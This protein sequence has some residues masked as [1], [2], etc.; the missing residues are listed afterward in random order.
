MNKIIK[1]MLNFKAGIILGFFVLTILIIPS[2]ALATNGYLR[3][4]N[5]VVDQG[6]NIATSSAGLPQ[7]NFTLHIAGSKD[8]S[9]TTYWTV[10]ITVSFSSN[11][12]SPNT[13][14]LGGQN[15]ADCQLF[16]LP[17]T[18]YYYSEESISNDTQSNWLTPK[19]YDGKSLSSVMTLSSVYSN[20]F[21]NTDPSDDILAN[22][23]SD[24]LV[25]IADG[26]WNTPSN[27]DGFRT[28]ILVNTYKSNSKPANTPPLISL[29]NGNP[30]T[31]IQGQV[32]NEPGAIATDL[33]D[34][35]ITNKIVYTGTVDTSSLGTS[36]LDYS[37]TDSGGLSASTTRNVIVVS[38]PNPS[39]T[40]LLPYTKGDIVV[41]TLGPSFG[42][43]PSL[44]AIASSS[45]IILSSQKQYQSFNTTATTTVY[46]K[47]INSYTDALDVFG[48]YVNGTST[49]T[50][51]FKVGNINSQNLPNIQSASNGQ[52]FAV[53]LPAG[54]IKFA[55]NSYFNSQTNFWS[56]EN[57]VN[58]GDD[59]M[60]AYDIL[61]TT[62]PSYLVA[63][64]DLPFN[65][66]D[67][68]YNDVV[69]SVS[70]ISCPLVNTPPL[71][72][73]IGNNPSTLTVGQTWNEPGAT[74]TDKEDGDLTNK[75]VITGTV[76]TTPGTYTL[77]YTVTDS[78]GLSA[79]TTRTVIVNPVIEN[80]NIN[81][82]ATNI[83]CD[84]ESDLPN[85]GVG[86]ADITASTTSQFLANH[87]NCRL[88]SDFKFQWGYDG[89][90]TNPG[91]N[92]IGEAATTTN[93]Y[94][95]GPTDANGV[96][97][98][99]INIA[100]TTGLFIREVLKDG[101]ILFSQSNNNVSAEMYC[102]TD[103]L[104]YDN[105]EFIGNPVKGQTYY[106]V[107]FNVLKPSLP[108]NTPPLISLIGNNPSTL[109]V[110]QTW[111]EPGATSTDKEDGDLTNKIV[112]TGTVGTTPGTY[113]LTYTVTDSGGLSAS[114]TRTVIVE[115]PV[116]TP[117]GKIK[118]CMSFADENNNIA[119]S[120]ANLPFGSFVVNLATSTNI[121]GSTIDSHTW[122]NTTFAPTHIILSST[123]DAECVIIDNLD[124][125]S[126]YYSEIGITGSLWDVRKYS[127]QY[128][129]PVNNIFD[130]FSYSP[131]LF[132]ATTTDDSSRNMNSDGNVELTN[133]RRERTIVLL[134][135][136]KKAPQCLVPDITSTLTAEATVGQ[137][138]SY[139]ITASSTA[140]TTLNFSIG[141]STLPTGLS[142]AT[143]TNTIFGVATQSGTF[144]I[145]LSATNSCGSDTKKLVLKVDP[146]Q[147]LLPELTSNTSAQAVVGQPFS[148]TLTASST[149]TISVAT[150]TLTLPAGLTYSTT[151]NTIS[152][153]PTETGTFSVNVSLKN[154][155]GV[156]S[157]TVSIVVNGLPGGG[158]G[159]GCT[160]NCGG[161]GGG[162]GGGN[163]PIVQN[164]LQ[165]FNEKV[166]EVTPGIAL[167]TWNTN[168]SA[169]KEVGYGLISIPQASSTAP[170]GYASSTLKI[171]SPLATV[172]SYAIPIDT[173]KTYYFRPVS[174]DTSSQVIGKELVLNPQQ[175][176]NQCYYL[177][178]YLKQGWDNNPV[179][180]K[181]LQVFLR[182]LEGFDVKVTGIYDD[183]TVNALNAFQNKY[184]DDIL[185]PWGHTAPTSF[186]YITTKKKVNEI[187]CK[188]AFPVTVSQQSEIDQYRNFLL[189]LQNAGVTLPLNTNIDG[190]TQPKVINTNEVGVID[191]NEDNLVYDNATG[192]IVRPNSNQ[193]GAIMT[194]LAGVS[195]TTGGFAS[196][197]AG[198][199]LDSGR[200][201]GNLASA[202][203]S[204]PWTWM[205]NIFN[206]SN[207]CQNSCSYCSWFNW[208]LAV[209]ILILSYLLYR[210][211]KIHNKLS[212]INKELDILNK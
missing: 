153:T 40:C 106:C 108:T 179:E 137:N 10:P 8:F 118:F 52:V 57:T 76:G 34:G 142:F 193:L 185:T 107:S 59:H 202:I 104:A 65:V 96:A 87:P 186:T 99:S 161:G 133:N 148:Y 125:G 173:G 171:S 181:K 12:F 183:Q 6:G 15:D 204:W 94:T 112:I 140:T 1:S 136:Y 151:T 201:L 71:I 165:I 198:N 175:G 187:Y 66:S 129:Q 9:L 60:V 45:S 53:T 90:V 50:P 184:K 49:F 29:I 157:A 155:C 123:K 127:D 7:G 143:T 77:T 43:E 2:S 200:I 81:L 208:I 32:W 117:K 58:G 35:N 149:D 83:V 103:V 150:T 162:G 63:F 188:K 116:S 174:T 24:G 164:T 61:G 192:T 64:E 73:L 86:G 195:S 156:K 115:N 44:M 177:F 100:S 135:G 17:P 191:T 111:N 78:G 92:L 98:T 42:S 101:Y 62:T 131:E 47:L 31:L 20:V 91:S 55:I 21:Y 176:D 206:T 72:S 110:G 194:T 180:V 209:V 212:E 26:Y 74:S 93:W 189:G 85:W 13:S 67:K 51:V 152:G 178:D 56:S 130:L 172:H 166:V 167:V 14:I 139:Q 4:C 128:N 145:Y 97:S 163:G 88:A 46:V 33:E 95:F 146:A 89:L 102:H 113:T 41:E 11:T 16:S 170:F 154:S 159:G 25:N 182:D 158:G 27:P 199:V 132:T 82:I 134:V 114:T 39:N 121:S 122:T 211:R 18:T 37:V 207:Q 119:T 190:S 54:E 5:M 147:C 48:Y 196:S 80:N 169:T 197:V 120:S 124:L 141:T 70:S 203:F 205:G 138:F 168:L 69:V 22:T 28:V 84:V 38:N 75:I 144:D 105:I 19:Y 3:V 30:L 79:S 210:E 68:D 109:T 23:N 160:S 126:Y 36:T